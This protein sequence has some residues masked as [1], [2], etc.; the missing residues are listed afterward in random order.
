VLQYQRHLKVA[1]IKVM[2]LE[3]DVENRTPSAK[4]MSMDENTFNESFAEL[5]SAHMQMW[6]AGQQNSQSRLKTDLALFQA[7]ENAQFGKKPA[8]AHV[9]GQSKGKQ[10]ARSSELSGHHC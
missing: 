9:D 1:L 4:L 6:I 3:L 7:R 5:R 10:V 2:E 8:R